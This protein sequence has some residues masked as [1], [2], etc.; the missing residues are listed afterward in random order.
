MFDLFL[1]QGKSSNFNLVNSV[2]S[3]KKN[4]EVNMALALIRATELALS[5]YLLE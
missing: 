2:H 4:R 5:S 3:V 1:G